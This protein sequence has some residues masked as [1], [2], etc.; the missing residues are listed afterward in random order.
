M[1]RIP[2]PEL[3]DDFEQAEAYAK[4]DF[5]E[6]NALFVNLFEQH[7]GD[8]AYRTVADLGCGPGDIS[9]ALAERHSVLEVD[10]VDGSDAMLS[11]ARKNL[12]GK[13]DLAGRVRFINGF[14]PGV[15]MP[16]ALYDCIV[17]NSLLHHL[18]TP[19]VMW[20][21]VKR[22]ATPGALVVVMDLLRPKSK[23]M[24]REIV[25]TYADGDPEVLRRD[26]Y[27]SLCAAF[28]PEEISVQLLQAGLNDLEVRIVS[29]RHLVVCGYAP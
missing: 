3:M 22:F 26:F 14:I 11:F 20:E 10:A 9:L 13:P 7:A 17:S 1:E 5:S 21:T 6:A 12:A 15:E 27:N 25:D 16:H 19:A 23:D 29:D 24:A 18:H 4:A 8:A 2:E 28:T